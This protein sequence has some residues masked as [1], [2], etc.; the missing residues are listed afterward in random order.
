MTKTRK[1]SLCEQGILL[2][3][4]LA[5]SLTVRD[6]ASQAAVEPVGLVMPAANAADAVE[7]TALDSA[8]LSIPMQAPPAVDASLEPPPAVA[9]GNALD[10]DLLL[11]P[12]VAYLWL[13]THPSSSGRFTA[14]PASRARRPR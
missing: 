6:T 3:I 1:A 13:F 2:L 8:P 11:I 12:C 4:V 10:P 5:C 14:S 7:R 9:P